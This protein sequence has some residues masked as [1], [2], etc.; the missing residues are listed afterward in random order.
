MSSEE[1]L[2]ALRELELQM[3]GAETMQFVHQQPA[4]ARMQFAADLTILSTCIGK[5]ENA[6]LSEIAG[7][8]SALDGD[9]KEGIK[10]LQESLDDIGQATAVLKEIGT[11]TGL[12]AKVAGLAL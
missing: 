3:R 9:L 12:A 2:D 10:N 1:L 7:R 6:Q 11:L 8:L 4:E 5:I